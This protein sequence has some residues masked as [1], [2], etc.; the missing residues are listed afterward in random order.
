MLDIQLLR[1]DLDHVAARLAARGFTLDTAAF[2]ALEARRKEVQT[3]SEELQARRNALSK[4][5][6]AIK[7]KGGDVSAVMAEVAGLGDEL[8]R[9]AER[10]DAVQAELNEWLLALPNLPQAD[11][12][13][14][15]SEAD[16]VEVRRWGEPTRFDYEPRDHVDIG[17]PLGLDFETAAKLSGS[18]FS[19]L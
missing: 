13:E 11:V 1:K 15:R 5:I 9:A 8:A 3:H 6:G 14:G 19:M 7:G 4:Q 16:N 18:R 10:N 17:A 2:R 12:P